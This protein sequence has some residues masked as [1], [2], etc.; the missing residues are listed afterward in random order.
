[1]TKSS[2]ATSGASGGPAAKRGGG[3]ARGA[4]RQVQRALVLADGDKDEVHELIEKLEPW[5]RPRVG[6]LEIA[7]DVRAFYKQRQSQHPKLAAR[8]QPD[9][10]IVLG[11]DGAILAAVRA[12][13]EAPVPTIG[14]NFGRV[15]FLASAETSRW[16]DALTEILD[17][18]AVIEPRMRLTAELCPSERRSVAEQKTAAVSAVALNDVVVTRGAFQGMLTLELK[19]GDDWL[20]NYRAD[21]LIVATP[22][23]STAYSLAAGG[24]ILAPSMQALVVTPI[25]PQALSHR[26]IVLDAGAELTLSVCEASGLTTLVIDGQGFY[27][28]HEGDSVKL[29][30]HPVAYPVLALRGADPYTRLRDRLGWR[31]SFEPEAEPADAPKRKREPDEGVL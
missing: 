20:T 10:V 4:G 8:E 21:G 12:F 5:L 14:I 18:R 26:A 28:M 7:A 1:M 30:R 3:V 29:K 2:R 24:P 6:A 25:C 11:G 22:S 16:R 17:G 19:V 23:G 31:G 15:G 27:P 9:L 13:A